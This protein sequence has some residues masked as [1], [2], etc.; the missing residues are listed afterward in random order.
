[1]RTLDGAAEIRTRKRPCGLLVRLGLCLLLCV[2]AGAAGANPYP[3]AELA[4][5]SRQLAQSLAAALGSPFSL[6]LADVFGGAPARQHLLGFIGDCA[7][8]LDVPPVADALWS[9]ALHL[10]VARG[11]ARAELDL[12]KMIARSATMLGDY[13]RARAAAQRAAQLSLRLDDHDALAQAENALGIVERRRGHLDK[14]T[15]HQLKAIALFSASGNQA[16]EIRALTDLGTVWRDRGEFAKALQVQLD[17]AAK[18]HSDTDRLEYL[19]RNLGLLY[20]DI[21]DASASRQYF[22]RALSEAIER[23][24]PTAYSTVIGSYASLLNDLGDFAGARDASSEALA[25]D[26]ALDD[27]PH[28]GLDLLELGRALLGL[29]ENDE[30]E[31]HLEHALKLGR[32]LQQREIVARSLLHLTQA[33]IADGD[34]LRAR[35]SIDEAIA[36]LE[37]ANLRQQL[38]QAY[39]MREQL[40]QSEG[41]SQDALRYAHKYL[42]AREEMIGV[43]TS[44]QLAALEV[45][46][47]RANAEQRVSMLAKDNELQAARIERQTL[48][49]DTAL[50]VIIGLSLTLGALVFRHRSMRRFNQ[51]LAQRNQEILEASAKLDSANAALRAQAAELERAATIDSLTQIANRRHLLTK[52]ADRIVQASEQGRSLV[53]MLIDFDHFKAIN[54]EHGHLFGDQVLATGA[55]AISER[56]SRSDLLGRYGG[57][58]FVAVLEQCPADQALA[59]ADG[60]REHVTQRLTSTLPVLGAKGSVSIGVACMADLSPPVDMSGFLDAAD[61]ALYAAKHAGRNCVRRYPT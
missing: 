37:A 60:V 41:N 39:A 40:A 3:R 11:D 58:E 46:H 8:A 50:I 10:A 14:A 38:A 12:N 20:R 36:G 25:I 49:R 22:D 15:K 2:S 19:Y 1:M 44:R 48:V 42:Q 21:E 53:L 35:G 31:R 57:E 52:L 24:S 33:A 45:Q 26:S 27:R 54:D 56:L 51:A 5:S 7:A 4:V 47:E 55:R 23:G 32:E 6:E 17:A 59:F 18:G 29:H 13:D 30:A 34:T 9:R 43:R 16:G 28:Q 61:Q